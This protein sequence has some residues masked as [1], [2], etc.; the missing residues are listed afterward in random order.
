MATINIIQNIYKSFDIL[1]NTQYS[2][3]DC[4]K[5]IEIKKSFIS[6]FQ[7]L[8]LCFKLYQDLVKKKKHA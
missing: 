6:L 8:V 5:P 3:L 1:Y 4:S 2:K 7:N